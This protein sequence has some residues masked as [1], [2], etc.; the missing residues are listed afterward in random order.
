MLIPIGLIFFY[1]VDKQTFPD[2][3]E[4]EMQVNLEWNEP[5]NPQESKKRVLQLLNKLNTP[6][7]TSTVA[8]GKSQFMLTGVTDQSETE[9]SFYFSTSNIGHLNKLKKNLPL[10]LDYYF[11]ML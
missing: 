10:K 5:V 7:V 1:I 3:E 6:V 11:P 8:I 2:I 9:A 4:T